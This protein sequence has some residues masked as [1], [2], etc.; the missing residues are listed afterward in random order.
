MSKQA[1]GSYQ[2]GLLL[3]AALAVIA[4]AGLAS[5]KNRWRTTWGAVGATTARI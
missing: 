4:L 1:T 2:A 3:F 5:I